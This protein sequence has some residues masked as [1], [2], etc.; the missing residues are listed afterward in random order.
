[1]VD[2]NLEHDHVM[3]TRNDDLELIDLFAVLWRRKIMIIIIT[4]FA[5]V[6]VVIFSIISLML[7]PEISP[8]P[9]RYTANAFMLIANDRALI[10][11]RETI[12]DG[13]GL[14]RSPTYSGLA[15]FLLKSNSLLDFVIDDFAQ[16]DHRY[17]SFAGGINR[18]MLRGS[19][20]ARFHDDSGVL[21]VGFTHIDPVFA[22]DIVN[23]F[24]GHLENRFIELGIDRNRTE[25]ASLELNLAS[26]FQDIL[27][28]EEENRRLEQSAVAAHFAGGDIPVIVADMNRIAVE[29]ETM[30]QVYAQLRVRN[31]VLRVTV[32]NE[33]PMF[34]ILELAEVPTGRSGPSRARLCIIVSFAAGV[35]S[36]ILAFI[37][38]TISNI[39]KDPE[40]MA[41]LRGGNAAQNG[42]G[43]KPARVSVP[44]SVPTPVPATKLGEANV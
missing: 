25:L 38:E 3:M 5:M 22:R 2:K 27:R 39:R 1:M 4:L 37:L 41:K 11:E 23:S 8:F 24:V 6:G 28:L 29:L 33:V 7:P 36:V 30:R 34:Q 40:A 32:A 31:E 15:V 13:A 10:G 26:V 43:K 14:R 16:I 42:Y 44:V 18:G 9:N 21:T 19:L 12:L 35:F 20:D 17:G